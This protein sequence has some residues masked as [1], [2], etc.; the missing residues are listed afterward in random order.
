MSDPLASLLER[1]VALHQ[2]ARGTLPRQPYEPDWPSPCQVGPPDAAGWI[3]WRP[4]RRK[5]PADFSG[6]ERALEAPLHPNLAAYFGRFWSD[7]V[8]GRTAEGGVSLIQI[9]NEQDFERLIE[10]LL[11]HALAKARARA[12]LTLFFA[13]TDE[14]ERFLSVDNASGRVLLEIPGEPPVREVAPDLDAFL[15]RVEP[16]LSSPEGADEG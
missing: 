12:P 7:V 16:V 15:A 1:Y 2:A 5:P 9:W 6:L 4:V 13:T 3:A 11:G 14:D 10:N 8:P